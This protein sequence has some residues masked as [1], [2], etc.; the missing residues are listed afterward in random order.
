M[1]RGEAERQHFGAFHG[2]RDADPADPSGPVTTPPAADAPLVVVVGNCQAESLRLLLASDDVRTVRLPA[3]HELGADD[4]PLLRALLARTDLFVSQPVGA[5]YRG[6]PLGT[7]ELAAHLPPSARTVLVPPIRYHGLH[8]WHVVAHPPGLADPDPPRAAYHDLRTLAAALGAGAAAYDVV[9]DPAALRELAAASVTELERR[10][11]LHGTV[12]VADLFARPVREAMRTVNH[13]GNVVLAPVAARVREAAGLASR[14]PGVTRPLLAGVH[15]PLEA[16]V[17]AALDLPGEPEPDWR[18]GG[19]AVPAAEVAAA[20]R[21]FYAARPDV[22]EVLVR[23]YA[24][25][26]RLLGLPGV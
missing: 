23:R 17:L 1:T 24:P 15:A 12:A 2:L 11:R 21:A 25:T 8:P 14:P 16:P 22:V 10:Q 18:I 7:E 19:L 6:L 5:G 20:H 4:V 26:M 13:P 3:I 9:P